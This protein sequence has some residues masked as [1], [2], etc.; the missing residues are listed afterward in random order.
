MQKLEVHPQLVDRV[1][2]AIQDAICA[3]RL[4]PGE[5][6]T[7]DGLATTLSVSRQPVLQA[8][9]LLKKQGFVRDSGRR[10]LAVAPLDPVFVEQLYQVRAALDAT[11]AHSAAAH[12]SGDAAVRGEQ[13]IAAGRA[14]AAARDVDWLIRADIDFHRFIYDLSGNPLIAETASLHWQHIRRMMGAVLRSDRPVE[15][16]WDEHAAILAAVIIG[17]A[18]QAE[19]RARAHAEAA[20][21]MLTAELMHRH[22]DVVRQSA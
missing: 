22:V 19:S 20:A 17:D 18:T 3:G 7:Q 5:R 21:R 14:A 6:I 1:Y 4:A 15:H 11:A 9:L 12:R 13:L 10:G 2:A 16:I 8:L